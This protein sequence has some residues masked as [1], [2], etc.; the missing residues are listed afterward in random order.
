LVK[1]CFAACGS[2][3][4]FCTETSFHRGKPGLQ[5]FANRR[6][7]VN[8]PIIKPSLRIVKKRLAS[9]FTGPPSFA[10][11]KPKAVIYKMKT[12]IHTIDPKA[13]VTISEVADVFKYND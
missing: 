3:K 4:D 1:H 9:W 8:I 6:P 5:P 10:I 7:N 13:F 12:I 2:E 11:I